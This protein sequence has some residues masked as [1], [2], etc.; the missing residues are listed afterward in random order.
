MKKQ[1]DVFYQKKKYGFHRSELLIVTLCTGLLISIAVWILSPSEQLVLQRNK[2]RSQDV[3]Y[4]QASIQ[5]YYNQFGE[6]PE[7]IPN[8]LTEICRDVNENCEGLVDF[9]LLIDLNDGKPWPIDRTHSSSA[10]IGYF[11]LKEDID[12]VTVISP[13]AENGSIVEIQKK[14]NIQ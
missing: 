12:M 11:I 5:K 3:E 13:G 7:G 1:K 14:Y 8:Y 2:K 9:S 10:G 4:I 6:L